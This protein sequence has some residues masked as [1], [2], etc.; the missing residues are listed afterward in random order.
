[1]RLSDDMGVRAAMTQFT[2]DEREFRRIETDA[3]AQ[4][5]DWKEGKDASKGTSTII[6]KTRRVYKNQYV[7]LKLQGGF[8]VIKAD[9]SQ[10]KTTSAV[11]IGR[12]LTQKIA[13]P[14]K[15]EIILRKEKDRATFATLEDN[16]ASDEMFTGASTM[17]S[18]TFFRF[19]IATRA[20]ALPTPANIQQWCH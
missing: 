18:D 17:K 13:R 11:G 10:K 2:E 6:E 14:W 4:F 20:D 5:L 19:T 15:I 12:D 9:G 16:L 3:H 7:G 1:M 8:M